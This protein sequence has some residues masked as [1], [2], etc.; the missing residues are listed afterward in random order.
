[1]NSCLYVVWALKK[2]VGGGW[3]EEVTLDRGAMNG[4]PDGRNCVSE[5]MKMQRDVTSLRTNSY[6]VEQADT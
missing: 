4:I 5:I 6:L 2:A 3:E 1:M